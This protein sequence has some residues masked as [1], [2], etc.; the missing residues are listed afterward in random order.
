[1]VDGDDIG[2]VQLAG[3]CKHT[4]YVFDNGEKTGGVS[5]GTTG[6]TVG[7]D[8]RGVQLVGHCKHDV[9]VSDNR[10]KAGGV[11]DVYSVVV[12]RKLQTH[13]SVCFFSMHF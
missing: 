11:D 13:W 1:V 9:V 10:E 2:G 12:Y 4:V 8:V 6:G 3:S 5:D 7:G